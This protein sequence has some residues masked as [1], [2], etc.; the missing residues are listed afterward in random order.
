MKCGTLKCSL[1]ATPATSRKFRPVPASSGKSQTV[2]DSSRQFQQVPAS[3]RK[4][5]Q[6]PESFGKFQNFRK[7][8][9]SSRKFQKVLSHYVP[10]QVYICKDPSFLECPRS[11]STHTRQ[12]TGLENKNVSSGPL[13][14][15]LICIRS[16]FHIFHS[17]NRCTLIM[18]FSQDQA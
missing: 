13:Y 14:W 5:R 17:Y 2:P 10:V 8:P 3:S 6:V 11:P 12:T 4:F 9:E 7:V 15:H 16:N 18:L 1:R